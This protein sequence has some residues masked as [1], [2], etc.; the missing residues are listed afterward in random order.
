MADPHPVVAG[1]RRRTAVVGAVAVMQ[2][3]IRALFGIALIL[4]GL[5]LFAGVLSI[6]YR[7]AP[8]A[9]RDIWLDAR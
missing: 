6:A 9:E 7:T 1:T 5:L 3:L 8:A 4:A 2:S